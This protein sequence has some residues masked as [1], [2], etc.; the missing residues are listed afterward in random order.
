[1]TR[2][3][4]LISLVLGLV[5]HVSAATEPL[6]VMAFNVLYKGADDA[7]SVQAIADEAPDILCLTEL[8]PEF[9]KTFEASLA[10]DYPHRSFAPKKGG[11]WGVGFAS[12]TPLRNVVVM[13]IAPSKIPAMEATVKYDGKEVRLTCVHLVPPVGKYKK[14]DT[15]ADQ[16]NKNAEVREKQTKTLVARSAGVKT[17]QIL[18]GD[19]NEEPGGAALKVLHDD[20]FTQGCGLPASRCAATFPGPANPW[21]AVFMVDHVFA[22]G[23]SFVEA[24]TWKRASPATRLR[25][26][27]RTAASI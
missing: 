9:I 17:P 12:K 2:I 6:H 14:T 16:F 1:M 13:P 19:F 4:R 8:T 15:L 18:L 3:V 24:R 5:S 22:R 11:T 20:G 23:F 21:P 27:R 25:R 7:K 26:S 10:K